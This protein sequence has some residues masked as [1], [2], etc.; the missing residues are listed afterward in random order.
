MGKV[1]SDIVLDEVDAAQD[2]LDTARTHLNELVGKH[3][4]AWEAQGKT[5]PRDATTFYNLQSEL[6]E[7]AKQIPLVEEQ[8]TLLE[9]DLIHARSA[10]AKRV[11]AELEP[12]FNE[13]RKRVHNEQ[14]KLNAIGAE[15]HPHQLHLR[16]AGADLGQLNIK[17]DKQRAERLGQL[18]IHRAPVMRSL[19]QMG[20]RGK[21]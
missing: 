19:W 11:I 13:Q 2:A 17:L 20:S 15:M 5:P 21:L 16:Q 10:K 1:M 6:D 9:I 7:L 4:H 12:E 3:A 8:I 18:D 14:T